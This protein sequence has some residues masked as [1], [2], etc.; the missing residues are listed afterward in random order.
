MT[1]EKDILAKNLKDF[2]KEQKL[3]QFEFAE[4]CGISKDTLSLIECS[5]ENVTI[6]TL[7]LLS[8]RMGKSVVDLFTPG[9]VKYIL[10]PSNVTTYGL[11]E[12][13]YGIAAIDDDVMVDYVPFVSKDYNRVL[14]TVH[15]C[16][17][18]MVS[19]CHLR[20]I[21]ENEYNS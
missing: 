9:S 4:D 20:D 13:T 21:I 5:K 2:R 7:Q 6:E 15:I 10:V 1:D 16:N 18:E 17:E 19:L 3:N 12:L 14:S 8:A 11:S